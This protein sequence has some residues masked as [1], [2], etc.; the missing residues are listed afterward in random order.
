MKGIKENFSTGMKGMK[1]IKNSALFF[2]FIPSIPFIPVHSLFVFICGQGWWQKGAG[3]EWKAIGCRGR[4][5][6]IQHNQAV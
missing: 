4:M 5:P 6:E 3:F 1:G 2:A